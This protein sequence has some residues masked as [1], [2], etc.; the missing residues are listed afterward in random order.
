MN[1]HENESSNTHEKELSRNEVAGNCNESCSIEKVDDSEGFEERRYRA[2][3]AA[4]RMQMAKK[5]GMS[6]AGMWRND[7]GSTP[8]RAAPSAKL[9][10]ETSHSILDNTSSSSATESTTTCPNGPSILT[11]EDERRQRTMAVEARLSHA[12]TRMKRKEGG[13]QKATVQ[14]TQQ[15]V[16]NIEDILP[17]CKLAHDRVPEEQTDHAVSSEQAQDSEKTS[18]PSK[19]TPATSNPLCGTQAE[20]LLQ[21]YDRDS[22]PNELKVEDEDMINSPTLQQLPRES[23]SG[24]PT[25]EDERRQRALAVEARLSQAMK[26]AKGGKGG[27]PNARQ[28]P[29]KANLPHSETAVEKNTAQ[30]FSQV[31]SPQEEE[32]RKRAMAIEQRLQSGKKGKQPSH[33]IARSCFASQRPSPAVADVRAASN[34]SGEAGDAQMQPIGESSGSAD[35]DRS[36]SEAAAAAIQRQNAGRAGI[37]VTTQTAMSEKRIKDELLGSI[38]TL[39]QQ[40]AVTVPFGLPGA[41][42]PNLRKFR[43]ELLQCKDKD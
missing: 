20:N 38:H 13:K 2:A 25:S 23:G 19:A 15:P 39:A 14:P 40:L 34:S 6:K 4:S 30:H 21:C 10:E 3:M 8:A 5:R 17:P 16:P 41:S 11:D 1:T 29:V 12:T 22:S 24:I 7:I 31:R 37:S 43:D 26:K 27:K 28:E 9:P 33:A 32:S 18:T 35:S 42:I 36:L